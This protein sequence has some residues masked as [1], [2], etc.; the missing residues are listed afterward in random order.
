MV[1]NHVAI[2]VQAVSST[3]SCSADVLFSR[4]VVYGRY[5]WVQNVTSAFSA[6][7]FFRSLCYIRSLRFVYVYVYETISD[8]VQTY[9]LLF[10]CLFCLFTPRIALPAHSTSSKWTPAGYQTDPHTP[11]LIWLSTDRPHVMAQLR[12]Q[13]PSHIAPHQLSSFAA[14]SLEDLP[15]TTPGSADLPSK[16]SLHMTPPPPLNSSRPPPPPSSQTPHRRA[17]SI[18]LPPQSNGPLNSGHAIPPHQTWQTVKKTKRAHL[19]PVT[20][21]LGTSSSFTSR[22]RFEELSHLSDDDIPKLEDLP[23]TAGTSRTQQSREHKPPPIYV[24]GVTIRTWCPT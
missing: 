18:T 13:S 6:E 24:Y 12:P 3:L 5:P 15:T 9:F 1:R 10:L 4:S 16:V 8:S 19:T 2:C 22:N 23:A 21:Q 17:R 7:V 11:L 20:S 14:P